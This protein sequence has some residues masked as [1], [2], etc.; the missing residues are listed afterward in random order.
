MFVA[1]TVPAGE[2]KEFTFPAP[3]D[4]PLVALCTVVVAVPTRRVLVWEVILSGSS[5]NTYGEYT[6]PPTTGSDAGI[7]VATVV[8]GEV[9]MI[10]ATFPTSFNFYSPV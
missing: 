1:R 5:T 3:H 10:P 4:A 2:D 9:V 6:V 7:V 8:E